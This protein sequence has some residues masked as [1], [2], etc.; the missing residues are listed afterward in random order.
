MLRRREVFPQL[1]FRVPKEKV[2]R[3]GA[4]L[5][6]IDMDVVSEMIKKSK[7]TKRYKATTKAE[8]HINRILAELQSP[9]Y[10]IHGTTGQMLDVRNEIHG[11]VNAFGMY[12]LFVTVNPAD[13]HPPLR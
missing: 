4:A 8:K 7:D 5:L 12:T 2:A 3:I 6:E 1:A 10:K 11:Y 13:L 9:G